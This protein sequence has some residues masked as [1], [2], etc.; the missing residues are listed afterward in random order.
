MQHEVGLSGGLHCAGFRSGSFFLETADDRRL[1]RA[2]CAGGP[3]TAPA[4]AATGPV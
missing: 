2:G 1:A 4:P 3:H